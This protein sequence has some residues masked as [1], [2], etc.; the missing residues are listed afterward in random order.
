VT[1]ELKTKLHRNEDRNMTDL[2]RQY[3][4][5]LGKHLKNTANSGLKEAARLGRNASALGLETLDVAEIHGRALLV[6]IEIEGASGHRDG[7]IKR[8]QLFFLEAIIPIERT[9]LFGRTARQRCDRLKKT[10]QERTSE[11]A[12]AKEKVKTS[13]VQR[14]AAEKMLKRKNEHYGKLVKESSRL[15]AT[16]RSLTRRVITDQE[17]ERGVKSRELHDEIAQ[18]LVGINMRLLALKAKGATD[19]KKFLRE[20]ASIQRLV[21]D[22]LTKTQRTIHKFRMVHEK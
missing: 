20:I 16:L 22:S 2:P 14:K 18:I 9:R 15:R 6:A 21:I 4:I 5:A 19:A 11:L 3:E 8:A 17:K 10:L 7:L 12:I 1:V 13:T